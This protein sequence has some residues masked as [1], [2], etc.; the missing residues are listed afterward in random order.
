ME[1]TQQKT[2]KG[3]TAVVYD[4]MDKPYFL[5]LKRVKGWEGWEF[6]KGR[7]KEGESELDAVKREVFEETGLPRF[8]IVKKLE[9]IKKEFI[10]K[11]NNL[12]IHSIYLI[13]ASMNIPINIHD[14]Q[15][16][17][18]STYLWTDAE[19]TMSKLTWDENKEILKKVLTE[20]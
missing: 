20:I 15:D 12:H 7:L 4:K 2:I 14:N 9:N 1:E 16:T 13:E 18:H 8:K 3:I 5:I 19:S 10:D 6:P 17:E 11:E